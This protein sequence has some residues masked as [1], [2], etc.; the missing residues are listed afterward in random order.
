MS[1]SSDISTTSTAL[2]DIKQA[3]IN[4]G[5]TPTGD[6]TTY[7]NAIGN[8]SGGGSSPVINSLSVTPSTTAQTITA[9]AGT[10]GYSPISV[11]AVTSDIDSNIVAGNIKDGVT[12]LGVT[13]DY[14]G[15]TSPRSAMTY[16][17]SVL[18]IDK[19]WLCD[20]TGFSES[21]D[22]QIDIS[23]QQQTQ[24][25][26]QFITIN[27]QDLNQ[28]SQQEGSFTYYLVYSQLDTSRATLLL[29]SNMPQNSALATIV[30]AGHAWYP[31]PTF[32]SVSVHL[33]AKFWATT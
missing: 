14:S 27:C 26:G 13:G 2:S 22:M 18:T 4:K 1:L 5:V 7:A 21:S 31:A 33:P 29:S 6:I 10:D 11:S 24:I 19:D 15:G 28:V 16:S 25:Q 9:P 8:I 3:I 32:T 17:G 12:I 23:Q 30:I 20:I